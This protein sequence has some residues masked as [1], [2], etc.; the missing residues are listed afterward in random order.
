MTSTTISY[1][2]DEED[3]LVRLDGRFYRFAEENGWQDVDYALGRSLWDY[4]TGEDL[5]KLQRILLRRVRDERRNIELPF[6]CDGPE[7]RREM[8]IRIG[9]S[10]SGRLV[11]FSATPRRERRRLDFQPLL[12]PAATRNDSTIQMCSWCDR[13]LVEGE[14]VE[15]EA[16]A[17]RLG[18][19]GQ[20]T[21]PEVEYELCPKCATMLMAA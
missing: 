8:D 1:A 6:R 14:W 20:P 17:E 10:A 2:I 12:D 9:A 11:L 4:V 18:L 13:F 5:R 21:L 7:V 19:F 3:R 15:V 16:A